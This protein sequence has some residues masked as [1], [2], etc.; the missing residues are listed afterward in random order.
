[1]MGR[2]VAGVSRKTGGKEEQ[3]EDVRWAGRCAA[4]RKWG[5]EV[6]KLGS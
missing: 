4:R 3:E 1:M 6:R 2:R 5:Y